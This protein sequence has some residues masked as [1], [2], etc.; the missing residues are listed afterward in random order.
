MNGA[1]S[2]YPDFKSN[3]SRWGRQHHPQHLH[4]IIRSDGIV[5]L[6]TYTV[7]RYYQKDMQ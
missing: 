2:S 5:L 1:H 4:N 6:L 3:D 7:V